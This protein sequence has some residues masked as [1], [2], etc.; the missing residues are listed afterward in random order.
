MA[1]EKDPSFLLNKVSDRIQIP[2]QP[3][4]LKELSLEIDKE[5]ADS[6]RI[7]QIISHDVALAAAVLKT[8]NSPYFG[9]QNKAQSIF[10]AISLLGF[11]N[12][13]NLAAGFLL[14]QTLCQYTIKFPRFWDEAARTADICGFI[15]KEWNLM[16]PEIP[17]TLGLFHNV[18]IP[19]LANKYSNYLEVLKEANTSTEGLFTDLENSAFDVDHA[20]IAAAITLEW[21]ITE[22]IRDIILYHHD[23]ENFF[24]FDESDGKKDSKLLAILKIAEHC[25]SFIKT[26][27][28]ETD[29]DRFGTNILQ[30]LDITESDVR[31]LIESFEKSLEK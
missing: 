25:D 20:V 31:K 24:Y 30:L 19:L 12:T 17:F 5:N 29:W 4:L 18:G 8:V 1:Y 11:E 16:P 3:K 7:A 26:G 28:N 27:E 21:G 14:K 23:V 6:S 10:H 2:P 15:A 9:L 22:A 13:R